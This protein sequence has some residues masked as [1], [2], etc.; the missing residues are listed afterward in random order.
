MGS[1][2]DPPVPAGDPPTGTSKAEPSRRLS[3]F[4]ADALPIPSGESP[5]GT[6]QWPVLPKTQFPNTLL[7]HVLKM[8]SMGDSPVPV[9][10][11]PTGTS[12]AEPS[13]RLS[14]FAADALPIPSGESPDGTGQWPVLPKTQ[15]PN[16]LSAI[17]RCKPSGLP[18]FE[19]PAAVFP[20]L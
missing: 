7:E 6:G 10:D 4:A 15:F 3:L 2:G 20:L 11:P 19:R 8:G 16:T 18:R 1:T 13:R 14:L 5:D 12:K 17:F 9:G